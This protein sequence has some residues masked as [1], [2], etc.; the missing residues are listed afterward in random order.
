MGSCLAN[1][2]AHIRVLIGG[3]TQ[4]TLDRYEA[5]YAAILSEVL[6]EPNAEGRTQGQ[7]LS[8]VRSRVARYCL[9]LRGLLVVWSVVCLW[10]V[11][12]CVCMCVT[13]P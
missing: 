13:L 9:R 12:A 5:R 3:L 7:L 6:D 8:E 4:G 2:I 11:R 10:Y 1:R